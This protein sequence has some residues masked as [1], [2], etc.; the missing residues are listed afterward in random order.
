MI[1][2]IWT[3]D[4]GA[5]V[6]AIFDAD[7]QETHDLTN[8]ITEHPVETGAD[9]SDNVR[10]NLRKFTVEGYVTDTPLFTDPGV[11][12]ASNFVTLE[13]QIPPYPL[14][15]SEAGLI[16]AG[17]DAIGSAL[18]GKPPPPTATFMK[19]DR[20]TDSLSRK[21]LIYDALDDARTNARLCRVFTALHEYENMLIEQITVT[22]AP[23]DG[24]GAV[25]AVSLKEV[26]FVSSVTTAAPE[27]AE[28]SGQV[29]SA[30][31]SKNVGDDAAK[32]DAKKKSVLAGLADAG[33]GKLGIKIP[34]LAG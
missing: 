25:F 5:V 7:Q 22:R 14:Q 6:A 17:L 31:G 28:V 33:A 19:L 4:A 9:I 27:P 32:V 15:L 26:S 1:Q 20:S 8:V 3:D 2:I 11:V 16:G 10:P 30:T 34:G 12:D 18:F 29:A 13:L 24:T 21:K 23:D